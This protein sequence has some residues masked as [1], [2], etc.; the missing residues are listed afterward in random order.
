M[1]VQGYR[2]FL[3]PYFQGFAAQIAF[4]LLLS[5][6][7]TL[8]LLSQ[9]LGVFEISFEFLANWVDVYVQG[10]MAEQLKSFLVTGPTTGNN[11]ILIVMAL[12]A[13][14]R[15]Q[16]AL[17]RIANYTYS[18]G[19]SSG[20]YWPE[21]FR[22][23]KTMLFLILTIGFVAIALVHGKMIMILIFGRV[24][25]QSVLSTVWEI[26]RWPLSLVLYFLVVLYEYYV[27]PI[28]KIPAKKLVPGALSAAVGMAVV[29]LIYS[30]YVSYIADYGIL[31]GSL[32]TIVALMF[33][34]FLLSWVLV[35]GI[36]VNKVWWDTADL[37]E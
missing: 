22:S 19:R 27:T 3:D 5:I 8:I 26:L 23:L 29:T 33:W 12:W 28:E 25:E 17:M 1:I 24:V 14:S 10:E 13:S 30:I 21:R 4:Y 20:F 36:M 37:A 9:I 18:G 31:Y 7:P 34:F 11:I 6:V 15:A 35:L 16:F 32:S 2:N